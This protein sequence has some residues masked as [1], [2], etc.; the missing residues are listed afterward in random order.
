[1]MP[2][3][4]L[5]DRCLAIELLVLDV[6]GVLTPGGII[7]GG[8]GMELKEF[9]VRD[10]SGLKIWNACGKRI[11]LITGRRSAAVEVRAE[12]LGI[13]LVVQGASDKLGAFN[14]VLTRAGVA[15]HATCCIGDDLPD[16]APLMQCGL[17]ITVS[18]ACP[19][20]RAMAHFVTGAAGG[21]GAV[22][23]AVELILRC[24]GAW[25]MDSR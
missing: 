24:Q 11:G 5:R 19:E 2:T 3:L 9:Y 22:R 10:G 21:R 6:D 12:E 4:S 13:H 17:A 15:P 23:E 20:A 18:D 25:P 1:M 7:H 8:G 14:D 16:L